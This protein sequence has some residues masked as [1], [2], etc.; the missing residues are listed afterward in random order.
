LP[1]PPR[2]LRRHGRLLLRLDRPCLCHA[3]V[4]TTQHVLP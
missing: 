1:Q 2:T 4:R 3:R